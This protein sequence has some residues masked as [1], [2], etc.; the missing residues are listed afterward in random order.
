MS[1]IDAALSSYAQHLAIAVGAA[2][3]RLMSLYTG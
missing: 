1:Y 2:L 3:L